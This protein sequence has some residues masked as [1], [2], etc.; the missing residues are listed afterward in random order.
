[1]RNSSHSRKQSA[2]AADDEAVQEARARQE[3]LDILGTLP[4]RASEMKLRRK[5]MYAPRSKAHTRP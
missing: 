2:C 4:I 3:A 1:M 5:D